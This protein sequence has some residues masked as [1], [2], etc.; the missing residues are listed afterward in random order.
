MNVSASRMRRMANFVAFALCSPALANDSDRVVQSAVES[1]LLLSQNPHIKPYARILS[2][3]RWPSNRIFVC[4][5]SSA[6]PYA[7]ER[8]IVELAIAGTWQKESLLQFI[9]WEACGKENSGIRIGVAD[10]APQAAGLGKAL[11]FVPNGITL[12]FDFKAFP[13]PCNGSREDCIRTIAVHEF[14]HA[15]GFTHEEWQ[16]DTPDSCVL[17]AKGPTGD[18]S[19][20]PFDL[21]SVMSGC[22]PLYGNRGYLSKLDIDALHELYGPRGK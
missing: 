12:N 6:L 4:W 3:A 9:G 22:N 20:T 1:V 7:S 21:N 2:S 11:D 13:L 17:G 19:L 8:R 18:R 10:K 5:E 16:P 14:G 15:L